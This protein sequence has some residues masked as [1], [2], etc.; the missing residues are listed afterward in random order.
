MTMS[1]P[2]DA[3]TATMKRKAMITKGS[4][5]TAST[6]RPTMRSVAPPK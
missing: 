6:S 2:A 1:D 3:P 5:S 4:A